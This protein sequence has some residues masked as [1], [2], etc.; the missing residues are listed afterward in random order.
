MKNP[1]TI[2]LSYDARMLAAA[3]GNTV[4]TSYRIDADEHL[5]AYAADHLERHGITEIT[6]T[7]PDVAN[8]HGDIYAAAV[9]VITAAAPAPVATDQPTTYA[10]S[11][12]YDALVFARTLELGSSHPYN[13]EQ[14]S[15]AHAHLIHICAQR[16]HTEANAHMLLRH[17]LAA[18]AHNA[19]EREHAD[20][21]AYRLSERGRRNAAR[22]YAMRPIRPYEGV[23]DGRSR[24][25]YATE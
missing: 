10:T 5:P 22:A 2:R 4:P 21:D 25:D 23:S 6:V 15:N 12:A 1:I 3:T 20:A 7:A 16:G 11:R 9:A 18:A 13:R 19:A 14:A 8:A 24:A 17:A